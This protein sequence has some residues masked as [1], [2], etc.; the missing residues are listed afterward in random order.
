MHEKVE[1]ATVAEVIVTFTEEKPLLHIRSV[2]V[3]A[4]VHNLAI[5]V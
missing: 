1:V 3:L 2:K 5:P 4:N